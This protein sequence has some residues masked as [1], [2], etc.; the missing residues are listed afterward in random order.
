MK[1]TLTIGKLVG[2]LDSGTNQSE[3]LQALKELQN[4]AK[5][6][7]D[8]VGAAALRK[9]LDLLRRGD[10][11]DE[12]NQDILDLVFR[13]VEI[14]GNTAAVLNTSIVLADVSNVEV[15]LD[16]LEHK[17]I[18]IGVSASQILTEIHTNSASDLERSIQ[19]CPNGV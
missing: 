13:L 15:L 10:G 1:P 19:Q 4:L 6:H 14:R 18:L 3:R 17:D 7:P 8:D 2:R 16:M 11:N 9:I 12:E 5:K